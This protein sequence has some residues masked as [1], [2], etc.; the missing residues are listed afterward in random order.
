MEAF[1]YST[2]PSTFDHRPELAMDGD[3]GTSYLTYGGMDDGDDFWVIL[4]T[5]VLA[6]SIRVS[7]GANGENLL[8]DALLETSQDGSVYKVAAQFGRDGTADAQNLNQP[9][10]S[11]KIRLR[12]RAGASHLQ[13]DEI[14]I[15]SETPITHVQEGPPRGFVDISQA[16]DLAK[17]AAKA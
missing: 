2:M 16:P 1:I 7:T 3:P 10:K 5:P 15:D 9:V 4:S 12:P 11:I 8:T 14:T 6:K 13:I 17:W